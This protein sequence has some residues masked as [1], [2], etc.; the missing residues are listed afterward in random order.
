MWK[1]LQD[2]STAGIPLSRIQMPVRSYQT[3]RDLSQTW[4]Q[5]LTDFHI[6]GN[7]PELSEIIKYAS[8]DRY[9]HCGLLY[10][11]INRIHFNSKHPKTVSQNLWCYGY[12]VLKP[13][14]I[15]LNIG[16]GHGRP[17]YY[18]S[19]SVTHAVI[20]SVTVHVILYIGYYN[21]WC[22]SHVYMIGL[23]MQVFYAN[24]RNTTA[25]TS[26]ILDSGSHTN[27]NWSKT[28]QNWWQWGWV[29]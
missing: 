8:V 11:A 22:C 16:R 28:P 26:G 1:T 25:P 2:L 9:S 18:N 14:V 21:N 27:R 5:Q 12:D 6:P 13:C 19:V 24:A 10:N 3:G 15:I 17:Q 7:Q 4:T 29:V 23:R 20:S